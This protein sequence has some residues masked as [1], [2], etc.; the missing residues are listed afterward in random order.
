MAFEAYRAYR[1]PRWEDFPD[2]ELY[3]DQVISVLE[4]QLSLFA[5]E[6]EKAIT[7]TMINNYVK[8]KLIPPPENKRYGR[9]QLVFLYVICILK[10]FMQLSRIRIVLENLREGK[11]D[12]EA[13]LFFAAQLDTA[14]RLVFEKVIPET[15]ELSDP[16][17][18]CVRSAVAAF[19]MIV[20]SEAVYLDAE[21][22]WEKARLKEEARQ[23]A[24]EE[25]AKLKKEKEKA[26]KKEK[27]KAAK[28]EKKEEK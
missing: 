1:A 24:A 20:Y 8:Q 23:K 17:E 22:G 25:K 12:E 28:E 11:S 15:K 14:M 10:K 9:S 2:I 5:P 4:K 7:S 16:A 18:S 26:E 13:Y 27:K 6:G 21:K 19:A 3:M